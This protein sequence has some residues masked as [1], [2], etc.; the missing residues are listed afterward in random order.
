MRAQLQESVGEALEAI[1]VLRLGHQV[2]PDRAPLVR[3]RGQ[4][5][6]A[7]RHLLQDVVGSTTGEAARAAILEAT[8]RRVLVYHLR[9]AELARLRRHLDGKQATKK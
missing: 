7:V 1:G 8:G 3:E 9:P 6:A 2:E 5:R 4:E